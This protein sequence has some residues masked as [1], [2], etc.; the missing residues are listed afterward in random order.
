MTAHTGMRVR[1]TMVTRGRRVACH[2]AGRP[3]MMSTTTTCTMMASLRA[4]M[5]VEI[6]NQA[7]AEEDMKAMVDANEIPKKK[8]SLLLPHGCPPAEA[9]P[10]ARASTLANPLIP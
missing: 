10:I 6:I 4:S 2:E 3:A 9:G 7:A 1:L 5:A 8:A